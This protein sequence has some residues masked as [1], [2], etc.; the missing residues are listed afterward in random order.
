M[1]IIFRVHFSYIYI[2]KLFVPR[3]RKVLTRS[4]S[5]KI[6]RIAPTVMRHRVPLIRLPVGCIIPC[7]TVQCVHARVY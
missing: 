3:F 6:A 7:D 4:S 2:F 1:Y 5:V